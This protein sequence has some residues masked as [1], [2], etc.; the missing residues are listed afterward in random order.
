VFIFGCQIRREFFSSLNDCQRLHSTVLHEVSFL[1]SQSVRSNREVT[2][3]PSIMERALCFCDFILDC[4]LFIVL[5]PLF[6]T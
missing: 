5:S 1:D 6:P 4:L 3:F 2:T